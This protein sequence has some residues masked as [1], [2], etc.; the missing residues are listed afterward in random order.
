[1]NGKDRKLFE[2]GKNKMIK[3]YRGNCSFPIF[4]LANLTADYR[5]ANLGLFLDSKS[6]N[7]N[8]DEKAIVTCLSLDDGLHVR[9]G[10]R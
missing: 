6:L 3:F 1:L 8:S 2:T 4:A 5:A 7:S 9:Q 10:T